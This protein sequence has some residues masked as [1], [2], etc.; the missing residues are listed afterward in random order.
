M[1]IMSNNFREPYF[2]RNLLS[3][4]D[5]TT[6]LSSVKPME[7]IKF[8]RGLLNFYFDLRSVMNPSPFT[9]LST[10]PLTRVYRLCRK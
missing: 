5:F 1:S 4:Y 3:N 2:P 7:K 10:W 8:N 6:K 9:V